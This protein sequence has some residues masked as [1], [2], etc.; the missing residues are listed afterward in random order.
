V[1]ADDDGEP[2]A[3]RPLPRPPTLGDVVALKYRLTRKLGRGGMGHIFA[4]E[5]LMLDTTVALKF[6]HPHLARDPGS[7]TRFEREAR[8]AATLKSPYAARVIDVD[9]VPSGELY[10]V[11]EY[12]EGESLDV[13]VDRGRLPVVEAVTYVLQA[14]HALSEA[15][16]RGIIHRDVKPANLFRTTGAMGD[17]MIKVLDFGLAKSADG[18]VHGTREGRVVGTPQYMSPEQIAGRRDIDGR[19]DVWSIG[20]T[21]Y[22]LLA[23]RPV[24]RATTAS[25]TFTQVL[26]GEVVSLL[27]HR[28]EVP[29]AVVAVIERCMMRDAA[30]RFANVRELAQA[31]AAALEAPVVVP[32]M[33]E[34]A[35]AQTWVSPRLAEVRDAAPSTPLFDRHRT[36]PSFTPAAMVLPSSA[37]TKAV[38]PTVRQTVLAAL[39]GPAIIAVAAAM[40]AVFV[41]RAHAPLA[42]ALAASSPFGS[43]SAAAS[44]AASTK[45][46][47]H[48]SAKA[49]VTA[50][51]GKAATVAVGSP[52]CARHPRSAACVAQKR[53]LAASASL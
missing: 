10:I 9:K 13:V 41:G 25:A 7:V 46:A 29:H 5:H 18:D 52:K 36:Q 35:H 6:M 24:F 1:V 43:S 3:L 26:Y 51:H 21:L 12:L 4:A 39:A 14:C 53:A 49:A 2:T 23:G 32:A 27:S 17:P 16:Q 48:V 31:L 28:P 15:H 22:E 19:T 42:H 40:M 45:S 37:N 20:V 47:E 11:M 33:S 8:A 50:R 44:P 30:D 34:T 38:E